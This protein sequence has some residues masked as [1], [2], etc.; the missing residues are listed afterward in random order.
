MVLVT[1]DLDT[2]AALSTRV[3]VLAEQRILACGTI[4][5]VIR[6]DHPFIQNFFLSERS[7]RVLQNLGL[8]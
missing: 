7:I 2:L 6:I 1:H 5:D 3:A 4:A 8:R